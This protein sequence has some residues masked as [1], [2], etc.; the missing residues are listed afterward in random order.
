MPCQSAYVND[1]VPDCCV[2]VVEDGAP[3]HT[4][5]I[6]CIVVSQAHTPKPAMLGILVFILT[7]HHNL[8]TLHC[9]VEYTN[10]S[11]LFTAVPESS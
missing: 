1:L 5:L 6:T 8:A 9:T 11:F 2:A 10:E 7:K 4:L 3:V